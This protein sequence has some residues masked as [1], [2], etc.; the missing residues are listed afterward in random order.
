MQQI[1]PYVQQYLETSS[2]RLV[3]VFVIKTVPISVPYL[4]DV[5]AAGSSDRVCREV[6]R[7]EYTTIHHIEYTSTLT[8]TL[9]DTLYL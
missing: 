8:Y 3:V 4:L 6:K 1:R 9:V 2:L 5:R 7:G